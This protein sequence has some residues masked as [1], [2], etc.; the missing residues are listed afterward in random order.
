MAR[1]KTTHRVF[2]KNPRQRH[3][4]NSANS[5]SPAERQVK[6]SKE[7]KDQLESVLSLGKVVQRALLEHTE[8][9]PNENSLDKILLLLKQSIQVSNDDLKGNNSTFPTASDLEISKDKHEMLE[10]GLSLCKVFE[11]VLLERTQI[12][13]NENS[14][15]AILH[16]LKQAIQTESELIRLLSPQQSVQVQSEEDTSND[17]NEAGT[18]SELSDS[19][20]GGKK[21]DYM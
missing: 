5:I 2:R 17:S 11:C 9:R 12:S 3:Y 19:E 8:I 10:Y 21:S 20:D 15:D 14:L 7:K 1:T 6:K 18:E 13:A 16:F 4:F